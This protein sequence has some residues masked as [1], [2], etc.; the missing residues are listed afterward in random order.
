LI[1]IILLELFHIKQT[2]KHYQTTTFEI[3][4]N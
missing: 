1:Q 4:K 3:S 2:P